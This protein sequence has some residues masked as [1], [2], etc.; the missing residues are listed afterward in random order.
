MCNTF[1]H[2]IDRKDVAHNVVQS[3]YTFYGKEI[4]VNSIFSEQLNIVDALFDL[5]KQKIKEI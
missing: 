3:K 2:K 5:A 4:V 1:I